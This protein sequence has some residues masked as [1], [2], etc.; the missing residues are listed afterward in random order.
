MTSHARSVLIWLG[1]WLALTLVGWLLLVLFGGKWSADGPAVSLTMAMAA[2]ALLTYALQFVAFVLKAG[3]FLSGLAGAVFRW[4]FS[5]AS[6]RRL[7]MV[8]GALASL[9][10]VGGLLLARLGLP[11]FSASTAIKLALALAALMALPVAFVLLVRVGDAG[12]FLFDLGSA[13]LRWFRRLTRR[14]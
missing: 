5:S 8:I 13:A 6:P 12:W 2:A 9:V 14:V 11:E 3:H 4:A 10:L 7:Y 1:L